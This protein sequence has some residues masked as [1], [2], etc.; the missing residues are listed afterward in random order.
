MWLVK[1]EEENLDNIEE[2]YLISV[3]ERVFTGVEAQINKTVR[4]V[5]TLQNIVI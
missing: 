2:K 3:S 5:I 1:E 4:Y